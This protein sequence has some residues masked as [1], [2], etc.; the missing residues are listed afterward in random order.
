[1]LSY[2][3]GSSTFDIVCIVLTLVLIANLCVALAVVDLVSPL[4]AFVSAILCSS[5]QIAS[6]GANISL[7][8]NVGVSE[9]ISKSANLMS[10]VARLNDV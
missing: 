10:N 1:M 4:F 2:H 7:E 6:N 3:N 8:S 9:E 5:R